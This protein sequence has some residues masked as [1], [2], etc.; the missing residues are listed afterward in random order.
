[1]M[2]R[3]NDDILIKTNPFSKQNGENAVN[4][5]FDENKHLT[6]DNILDKVGLLIHFTTVF[7]RMYNG[8]Q[9]H[10]VFTELN[11]NT[12]KAYAI[13]TILPIAITSSKHTLSSQMQSKYKQLLFDYL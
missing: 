13:F 10:F 2:T 9:M 12:K 4:V 7:T 3:T 6:C 1:M 11:S 5:L 8:M